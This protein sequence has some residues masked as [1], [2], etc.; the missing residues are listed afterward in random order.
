MADDTSTPAPLVLASASPRRRE[1][2]DRLG[3]HF[4]VV[5]S[6]FEEVLD[7]R[8]PVQQ[9]EELARGKI[10]HLL[11][12]HPDLRSRYVLGADTV[13]DVDGRVLGKPDDRAEAAEFLSILSG[14][15]HRVITSLALHAPNPAAAAHTR[16]TG[17]GAETT[18][19][20]TETTDITVAPLS[21]REKEW[22]LA[23]GEWEGA[24]GGYRIQGLGAVFI[25]RIEGCYFNE[26]GLPLRLFYVMV[27]E[28]GYDLLGY[29]SD[30]SSAV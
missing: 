14:R 13:I 11:A 6:P 17:G 9:S 18:H 27:G 22:Y 29:V 25:E 30:Q 15:R 2:L 20:R 26:M 1:L 5:P 10:E 4:D 21:A 28:Y 12:E 19:V 8:P 16:Q 24:A 3:L 23:T 7:D